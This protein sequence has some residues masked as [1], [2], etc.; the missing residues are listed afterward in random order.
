MCRRV[1]GQNV[2]KLRKR[3]AQT[4]THFA[5]EK[6]RLTQLEMVISGSISSNQ[7]KS[8]MR[9]KLQQRVSFRE[10]MTNKWMNLIDSMSDQQKQIFLENIAYAMEKH[11][12]HRGKKGR[13]HNDREE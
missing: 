9:T 7:A 1:K 5:A 4:K 10:N 12:Q 8:E 13:F 11:S 6:N 2:K 3:K